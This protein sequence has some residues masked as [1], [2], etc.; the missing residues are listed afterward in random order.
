MF[1]AINNSE[2][3]GKYY[4]T[5]SFFKKLKV[6]PIPD[7]VKCQNLSSTQSIVISNYRYVSKTDTLL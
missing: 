7:V 1:M 6:L 5:H 4:R 2:I 3:C